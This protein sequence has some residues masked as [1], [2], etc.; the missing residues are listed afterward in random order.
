VYVG[1]SVNQHRQQ[2]LVL[3][4]GVGCASAEVEHRIVDPLLHVV[5]REE[6]LRSRNIACADGIAEGLDV[7]LLLVCL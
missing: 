6:P 7:A 5:V 4:G 1:A 3:C 2:P